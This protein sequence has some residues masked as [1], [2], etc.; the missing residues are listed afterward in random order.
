ME[1]IKLKEKEFDVQIDE[2]LL[3]HLGFLY[4]RDPL[5]IFKNES[6]DNPMSTSDFEVKKTKI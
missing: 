5:V 3:K 4:L 6:K 2:N 1:F